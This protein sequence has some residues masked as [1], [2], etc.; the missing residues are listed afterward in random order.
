MHRWTQKILGMSILL[1]SFVVGWQILD[2]RD[3]LHSPLN[4]TEHA[5]RFAVQP[6]ATIKGVS[7]QLNTQ[8][9]TGHPRYLEWTA[10]LH[11]VADQIKAGEYEIVPGM[12]PE[13]FI[14]MVVGGKVV[15]YSITLIEGWNIHQ[16]LAALSA[17][18]YLAHDLRGRPVEAIMPAL[19][20]DKPHPEGW[21]LPDTYFFIRGTSD[22]A[23]L[24]RA[25]EAMLAYLDQAWAQRAENLPYTTSYEA[26]IM[27]SIVEK[28][29]AVPGERGQIA[30]VF[31]RRLRQDMLLQTDPTIIYGLGKTYDGN[32]RRKDLR[33][34][35]PYNTYT[36]KGLPP[37]PIA[38]P[39]RAA[40][41][42]ALHPVDNK[43]LFF[44]ARGDG[45]HAFAATLDEHNQNVIKYQLKGRKRPFSSLTESASKK[46][47]S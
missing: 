27:A 23:I 34:D 33:R 30:G 17:N 13:Q 35:T 11:G 4:T 28:E 24:R 37:T 29:T 10:R 9:L 36:R 42:A 38:M 32:I 18:E 39:G 8:G 25:H 19:G 20:I 15:Q 44:V 40:I 5:I 43:A 1:L 2:Y 7:S 22:I 47:G 3:F 46:D 6:G 45:S 26:L 41:N 12:K 16:V 21:F 31:I 14:D